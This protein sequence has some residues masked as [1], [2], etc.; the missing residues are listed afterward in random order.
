M[1]AARTATHTP[2]L[3]ARRRGQ[4]RSQGTPSSTDCAPGFVPKLQ[5]TEAATEGSNIA[6]V[7]WDYIAHAENEWSRALNSSQC[8]AVNTF[9]PLAEDP[10][11]ARAVMQRVLP[12]DRVAPSDSVRVRFEF[13]P[14]DA[15]AWLGERGQPTQVDVYFEI[16]RS[17]RS[18]GHV[19]VEVKFSELRFGCCRGWDSMSNGT[20]LNR[21]R[22]RCLN[23]SAILN[24]PQL[25]CWLTEIEGRRYW[26]LISRSDSSI[27]GPAI[28][29]V[30]PCPFRYGLY[31][32]MRNR[33][34][35]DELRRHSG[36]DWAEFAVCRHPKNYAVIT[37]DEPVDSHL[38]AIEA[39]RSI[40]S[41]DAI[42]DWNAEELVE[43]IISID[44]RLVGWK[45]WMRARYFD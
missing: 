32:L 5:G 45:E 30:G 9:G 29:T 38:N 28:E 39:L 11:L 43:A 2:S 23:S 13:T 36:A 4:R 16:N 35:A 12:K 3:T 33:V 21:D 37:L 15:P 34:L 41:P 1:G 31:Q 27:S 40:S 20:S 42:R 24:A 44:E 8:F 26:E 6:G 25:N 18:I 14:N 19:L 10:A 22:S 17:G 7:W